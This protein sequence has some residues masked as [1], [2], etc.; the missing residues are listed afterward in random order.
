[1]PKE[2]LAPKTGPMTRTVPLGNWD[3][4]YSACCCMSFV[5]SG[6]MSVAKVGR[7]GMSLRKNWSFAGVGGDGCA[8]GAA[9]AMAFGAPARPQ[10]S[11]VLRMS[12]FM[13]NTLLSAASRGN[14]IMRG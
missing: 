4:H 9:W 10:R 14:A 11:K 8:E 7:G 5:S 3:A 12:C 6:V 2:P 13:A 1:M